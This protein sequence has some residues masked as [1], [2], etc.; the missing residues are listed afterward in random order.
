MPALRV[1]AGAAAEQGFARGLHQ[2]QWTGE[3]LGR[4]RVETYDQ[5]A[6]SVDGGQHMAWFRQQ[7]GVGAFRGGGALLTVL[8]SH[9]LTVPAGRQRSGRKNRW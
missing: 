3:R 8:L 5:A 2:V 9:C 6:L 4:E 7:G 1:A